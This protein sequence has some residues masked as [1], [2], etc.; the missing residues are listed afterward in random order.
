[1]HGYREVEGVAAKATL[2][3]TGEA[4][5][6]QRSKRRVRS[7]YAHNA[8]L[9]PCST[10][11]QNLEPGSCHSQNIQNKNS[12]KQNNENGNGVVTALRIF[13]PPLQATV[14]LRDG[15]PARI[16]CPQRKEVEGEIIWAAGPWRS[17]GDWW[18]QNGWTRDEW[19]VALQAQSGV[20]LY[21]LVRDLLSGKWFVE[22]SYD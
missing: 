7:S 22:G 18:E 14:T 1:M 15:S 11:K 6:Y 21:R 16:F 13:R 10:Q 9:K 17:S 20:G 19:D 2:G 3:A 5:Y 12:G 4:L 8:G